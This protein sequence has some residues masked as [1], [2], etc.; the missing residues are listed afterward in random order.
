MPNKD[1]GLNWLQM[2]LSDWRICACVWPRV[3]I[4]WWCFVITVV[5]V[6]SFIACMIE[7][8][9]VVI[10][11]WSMYLSMNNM[12]RGNALNCFIINSNYHNCVSRL[13]WKADQTTWLLWYFFEVCTSA[14]PIWRG[15][16]HLS[17]SLLIVIIII[18]FPGCIEKPTKR[19]GQGKT[20][21][22]K[23]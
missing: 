7:L 22:P 6:L 16:M 21:D 11:L 8:W 5:L 10:V 2:L 15:L 13:Y 3:L 17:A 20:K 23:G 14:W 19:R 9:K 4:M 12:A 18:V 1:V